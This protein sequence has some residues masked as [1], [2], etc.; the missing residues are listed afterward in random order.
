MQKEIGRM[1]CNRCNTL[2]KRYD[3][4]GRTIRIR[5]GRKETII[6]ERYRCP[7]CGHIV[8]RLPKEVIKFKQYHA[9]VIN[10]VLNGWITPETLGFEDNPCEQTMARWRRSRGLHGHL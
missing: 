7:N 4:V 2:M 3:K 10:G 9:D 5:Y 6:L 1:I 8:R